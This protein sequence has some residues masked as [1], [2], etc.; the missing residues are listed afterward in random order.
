MIAR[1]IS[2]AEA[3]ERMETAES[4][5]EMIRVALNAKGSGRPVYCHVANLQMAA[6]G[7][8]KR[9]DTVR[10]RLQAAGYE[11]SV[12]E[13]A[14]GGD[15]NTVHSQ[16][17]FDEWWQASGYRLTG[18]TFDAQH[19]LALTAWNA[20]IRAAS[21]S[22]RGDASLEIGDALNDGVGKF[23]RTMDE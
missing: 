20:G 8:L 2:E 16:Y 5:L 6:R 10:P 12:L 9:L 19:Q 22:I 7:L 3:R 1:E 4:E 15:T 21:A 23:P 11:I 18:S 17:S 14:L 13:C